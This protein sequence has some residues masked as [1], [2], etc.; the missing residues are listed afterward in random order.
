MWSVDALEVADSVYA[1]LLKDGKME[2][3]DAAKALHVAV[4][5]LRAKRG[6]HVF[7]RWIPYIH[8]GV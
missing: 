1:Q 6:E 2:P 5:R 7:V 8:M 4:G 3:R